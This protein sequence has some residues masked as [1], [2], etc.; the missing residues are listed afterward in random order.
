MSSLAP[1]PPS[2]RELQGLRAVV[3]GSSSGIGRA[4]A[5]EL[6]AAGVDVLVHTRRNLQGAQEVVA[7]VR[8]LGQRSE[9]VAADLRESDQHERL[10]QAAWDFLG[11]VEVW[12]NNAGADVLTGEASAGSFE[13]K[14]ER[15]W[16]VDVAATVRLSRLV[17]R[18]MRAARGQAASRAIIN[19]G[20]DQA[21]TGMGGESGELFGTVKGA[22]MA[23]TRS[24]AQTLA[25]DIR[26][27]CVA[28][29]WIR[30]AW[31][32]EASEYWQQRGVRESLR[33]RWGTPEDVARVVRFLV[34][35]AADFVNGQIIPV[36]G[37]FR[38]S[39]E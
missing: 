21:E 28:P 34:S 5:L 20:W 19:M 24:L 17:G 4:I 8:A 30:T 14:F 31:G 27:N 7:S 25:P 36:N 15:L 22:V 26:V 13:Q 37:G 29:G 11:D 16:Q 3:T 9:V 32:D 2:A 35:P 38:P 6:A 12:V 18:R 10:V 1:L 39:R 23:F 33:D